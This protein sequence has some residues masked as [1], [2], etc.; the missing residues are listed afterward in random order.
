MSGL[1]KSS[2]P[3]IKSEHFLTPNT[4]INSKWMKVLN[5]TGNHK[6]PRENCCIINTPFYRRLRNIFF[7]NLSTQAK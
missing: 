6:T 4:K 5:M 7:F 2:Q 1:V 3:H